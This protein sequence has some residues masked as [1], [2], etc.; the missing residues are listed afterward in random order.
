M[1]ILSEVATKLEKILNGT[2]TEVETQNPVGQY[3]L[4]EAQGFHIDHLMDKQVGTNFIPVF[5]SSMGGQFNP[6]ADLKQGQYIIPI[7]FYFPVRFKD[8]FF[9]LG[10]F[11]IDVFVGE[12]I[13][14]GTISGSGICN[15]SVP[16]FGEITNFDLKEFE[17]WVMNT[18]QRQIQKSEPFMSM[19][20][21]LYV[22]NAA[23][24][25]VF[26]NSVDVYLTYGSGSGIREK[27]VFVQSSIQSVSQTSSE[28]E[29][30]ASVPEAVGIPFG[31]AYSCGFT[32]Y[33]KN[34]TFWK[35]VL[36]DWADGKSQN[37]TFMFEATFKGIQLTQPP[38]YLTFTRTC[39]IESV[40]FPIQKGQLLTITFS[41]GKKAS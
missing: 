29:L 10:D 25:F 35:Y 33:V 28:Q 3:F 36:K 34:T 8:D 20:L 37:M 30:D 26:G 15:V 4:V 31:T 23:S 21:N 6:V 24:G 40:N 38:T 11:L 13:N 18:Y 27:M 16:T 12:T 19:T 41:F 2:D 14:F 7:T 9:K 32:A 39:Y 1:I 17:N 22:T 5:V